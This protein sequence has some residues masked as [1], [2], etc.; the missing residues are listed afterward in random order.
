MYIGPKGYS[1]PKASIAV[2]VEVLI[3]KDLKEKT[4]EE[5]EKYV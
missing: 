5:C 3:K 4:F 1:I 2:N